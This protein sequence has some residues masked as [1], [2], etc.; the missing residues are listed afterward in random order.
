MALSQVFVIILIA[1]INL[2]ISKSYK[3]D[4][5]PDNKLMCTIHIKNF[6]QSMTDFTD[7]IIQDNKIFSM[8]TVRNWNTSEIFGPLDDFYQNLHR[9]RHN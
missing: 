5:Y 4:P 9:A 6:A 2:C 3:I 8:L 1:L 7:R